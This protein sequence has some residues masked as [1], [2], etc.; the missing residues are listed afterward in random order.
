VGLKADGTLKILIFPE[1][2]TSDHR[3]VHA[4]K[5]EKRGCVSLSREEFVCCDGIG[6]AAG[7]S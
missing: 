5:G 7:E 1:D 4:R 2:D 6:L 3:G